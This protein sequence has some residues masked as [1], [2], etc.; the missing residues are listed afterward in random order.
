[1]KET[2][3]LG[4]IIDVN[5]L[6]PVDFL[7]RKI[8]NQNTGV[9]RGFTSNGFGKIANSQIDRICSLIAR[10]LSKLGFISCDDDGHNCCMLGNLFLQYL[11]H[12]FHIRK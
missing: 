9:L 2:L 10:E 1:M 7:N 5:H 12:G 8:A 6:L 4:A 3:D 11:S